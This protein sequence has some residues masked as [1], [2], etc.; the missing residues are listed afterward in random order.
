MGEEEE[1]EKSA[2]IWVKETHL[3]LVGVIHSILEDCHTQAAHWVLSAM[4]EGQVGVGRGWVPDPI[5][6]A[7]QESAASP[8]KASLPGPTNV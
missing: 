4:P 1:Y 6:S 7:P 8:P 3:F 2:S 5:T